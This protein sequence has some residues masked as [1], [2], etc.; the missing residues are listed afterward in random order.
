MYVFKGAIEVRLL[1]KI[2]CPT[3]AKWQGRRFD[4]ICKTLSDQSKYPGLGIPFG[5][6]Y[7]VT[8]TKR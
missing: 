3:D 8:Q 6:E 5:Q 1:D 2:E 4:L 7:R